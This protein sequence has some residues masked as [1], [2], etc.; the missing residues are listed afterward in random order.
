MWKQ[1]YKRTFWPNQAIILT[2]CLLL[3]F[4]WKMPLDGIAIFWVVMEIG[5]AAG[6]N[7]DDPP[8]REVRPRAPRQ[9][10]PESD[11]SA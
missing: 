11:V 1:R 3:A 2:I 9:I 8:R 6:R 4:H 5:G 10:R 7:V